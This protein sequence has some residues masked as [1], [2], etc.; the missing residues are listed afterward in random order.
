MDKRVKYS[1][2]QKGLAVRSILSGRLSIKGAARELGCHKSAVQRW[3]A[4]Y[5]QNG[6]KGLKFRNGYYDDR[7]KLQ[8][9]RYHIKKGLSL[10]ETANHFKIPNEA[11]LSRWI[12]SY[13][14]L[15]VEG[16]ANKGRGRKKSIMTKKPG[17]KVDTAADPAAQKLV[18]MQRELAYLRAENAFLKK[19]SALVQQEEAAKA[20]ARRPKSSGN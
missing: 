9:V 3:L 6:I 4:Q 5:K 1:I 17:K 12:R 10:K 15:G 16:L 7:F 14:R 13:E 20:Q 8:V 2:K 11:I 18:E 19:L